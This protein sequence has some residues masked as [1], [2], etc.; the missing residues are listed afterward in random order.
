MIESRSIG[1]RL[2]LLLAA[3]AALLSVL[4]WVMVTWLAREA[5]QR[6]QDNVL[7]A[8]ATTIAETL[9][10]EQGQLRLEL[11]YSALAMLGAISEDRVFY[12]VAAG[13][14][15][16]T[17]YEDMPPPTTA[18]LGQVVFDSA[19]FR[20]ASIRM[21]TSSRQV[22]SGDGPVLVTVTVGQTRDGVGAVAADLSRLAAILS[23]AF[24]AVA[25]A[26]SAFVA[27]TSLRPLNEIAAAVSR[28]GPSDLRPLQRPAPTELAPLLSA[29]NRLMDR[30]RNSIRRSEDFIA[31]AAHRIRTPL[32][33]VRA[34]AE[35]A[36]RTVQ[37]DTEKQ[38]LRRI[39]RAVDESSRS[40]GQLLDHATVAYRTENLTRDRLDL[41]E[42]VASTVAA[43]EP[44][45]SMRDI[46][47]QLVAT[48]APIAGDSILLESAIRNVLDN[49]IK[50]SPEDTT[51]TLQITRDPSEVRLDVCDEGPGLGEEPFQNLTERFRRGINTGGIVGSGLGL[52]I[53][54]EVLAAH[55]GRL[56]LATSTNSERGGACVSLVLPSA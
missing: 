29:L 41:S 23:V 37:G 33:T 3:V 51:V 20:G 22:L 40:A 36:L 26:L 2:T 27:T 24:F 53:V 35:I 10:S 34:Q 25:V 47:M 45:A 44:T 8:S 12:R 55:G 4:S 13:E 5:T 54:A 18:R 17:G 28:R 31:E 52:T 43:M 39:I 32:A 19:T 42:L 6:T 1:R 56:D 50:Y 9:R 49:A 7:A 46:R 48:P 16:L 15:I 11:P 21:A 38:R 14:A 30:L